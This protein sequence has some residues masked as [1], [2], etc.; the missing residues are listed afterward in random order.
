[1]MR[2][3]LCSPAMYGTWRF[4]LLGDHIDMPTLLLVPGTLR[5]WL[6]A[7]MANNLER[8]CE[9]RVTSSLHNWRLTLGT[10]LMQEIL[11]PVEKLAQAT[12]AAP[13]DEAALADLD[14]GF[15]CKEVCTLLIA[16]N[17]ACARHCTGQQH[18]SCSCAGLAAV[19]A[20]TCA[21]H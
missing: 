15:S 4:D 8:V 18:V 7:N 12:S 10:A 14:L 21:L 9:K 2:N 5:S 20:G 17:T 13:A 3:V 16:V 1:M 19:H 11:T 6:V